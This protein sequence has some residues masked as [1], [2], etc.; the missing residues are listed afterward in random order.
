VP[1][2]AAKRRSYQ[3]RKHRED[4]GE[5]KCR[6]MVLG[7]GGAGNNIVDRLAQDGLVGAEC[8][9]INTDVHDLNTVG[10]AQRV[11]IGEKETCGLSASGKPLIGRA[12]AQESKPYLGN[13]L[14]GAEIVFLTAGLGGG[15]GTGA[16]PI[17]ADIARSKGA[18][19]VGV[20]TTPSRT[21][22]DEIERGS[23]ALEELRKACDTVVVIDGDKLRNAVPRLPAKEAFKVSN[24]VLA[25]VIKGIVETISS[26]SLINMNVADFKTIVKE[27]GM[28]V[29]G[30]G[31]CDAIDRAKEAVQNALKK[32]S[33]DV[34]YAGAKGALVEVSGGPSMTIEDANRV[35]ELV[36]EMI[37]HNAHIGWGARVNPQT[38][39]GMKV[40]IVM[41][42][43]PSHIR[44]GGI[45][46]LM[47]QLFD[48]ESFDQSSEHVPIE[49]DLDQIE[50]FED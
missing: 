19:V 36:A 47:P 37:G 31:E 27:G 34:D 8:V 32:P 42:G 1:E 28:A 9:A 24:Q 21:N 15:T 49:L 22:K 39:A 6:I 10:S 2:K 33:L 50:S 13:L 11:L 17:V 26:P 38:E 23:S 44:L 46:N 14:K 5:R 16:A 4:S 41:T 25:N 48:I 30:M 3:S 43:M 18:V 7:I 40:T 20:V 45:G 35:E 12:A 29:L